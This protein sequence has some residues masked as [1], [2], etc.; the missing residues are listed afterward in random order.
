MRRLTHHA[1][2]SVGINRWRGR[3]CSVSSEEDAVHDMPE[4]LRHFG[5]ELALAFV[6]WQQQLVEARVTLRQPRIIC[7]PED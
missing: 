1:L 5:L 6:L 4:R 3:V 7:Y 2:V